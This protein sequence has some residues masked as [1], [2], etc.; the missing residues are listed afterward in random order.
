M[1]MK[2]STKTKLRKGQTV[3]GTLLF[4]GDPAVVEI[5]ALAGLDFVIIDSEHAPRDA[6]A[7][8]AMIRAADAVGITPLVRVSKLDDK[9]ILKAL[10]SGAQGIVVPQLESAAE[11][12]QFVAATRYPPGGTRS[13]CR[14]TRA[15]GYGTVADDFSAHADAADEEILVVG[16]IETEAGIENLGEILDAGI[17]VAF[18]GRADLSSSMG[19]RG[20]LDNPEVV[21]A[22]ERFIAELGAHSGGCRAGIVPYQNADGEWQTL[23]CPFLVQGAEVGVLLTGLKTLGTDLRDA[24]ESVGF[25]ANSP[26]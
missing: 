21:R 2:N 23:G 17:D 20:D 25:Q 26:I 7:I 11:A 18:L 14:M 15:G 12:H 8:E 6:A 4:L 16:L 3:V 22:S 10:E 19:F 24:A 9:D 13:T 1:P 5:A